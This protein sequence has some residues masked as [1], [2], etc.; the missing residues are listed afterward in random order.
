MNRND[1]FTYKKIWPF[2][3]IDNLI[4]PANLPTTY[5][6]YKLDRKNLFIKDTRILNNYRFNPSLEMVTVA[7]SPRPENNSMEVE[8]ETQYLKIAKKGGG[9]KGTWTYYNWLI[10][11]R[12]S[13]LLHGSGCAYWYI[14]LHVVKICYCVSTF[15]EFCQNLVIASIQSLI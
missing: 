9:H 14:C 5:V 11:I 6:M 13:F 7:S 10:L 2:L 3:N 15:I 8:T 12:S 4:P 1:I